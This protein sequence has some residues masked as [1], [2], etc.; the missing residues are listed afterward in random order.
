MNDNNATGFVEKDYNN[1]TDVI[2]VNVSVVNRDILYELL[3]TCKGTKHMEERTL[4]YDDEENP[5]TNTWEDVEGEGYGWLWLQEED[6]EEKWH[7]LLKLSLEEYICHRE[8]NLGK[9]KEYVIVVKSYTQIIYHF[10][11][12]EY[13]ECDTVFTFSDDD[14][15]Y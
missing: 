11:E 3:I 6:N 4:L 12:R 10:I 7:D 5:D 14:I 2:S 9:R 1:Q 8:K 15:F 13:S